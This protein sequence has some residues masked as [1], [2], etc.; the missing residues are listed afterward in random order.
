MA[1]RVDPRNRVVDEDPLVAEKAGRSFRRFGLGRARQ[2]DE[3]ADIPEGL[4]PSATVRRD[5]HYRRALVAADVLAVAASGI[6]A[7]TVLGHDVLRP[8]ACLLLPVV[9][10][11]SKVVGLYDRDPQLLC[12]STL[13][14]APALFQAATF[15]ALVFWVLDGL[16]VDGVLGNGQVLGLWLLLFTFMLVGRGAARSAVTRLTRP[17]RCLVIGSAASALRVRDNLEVNV[18]VNGEVVGRVPLRPERRLGKVPVASGLDALGLTLVEQEIDRVLV[19]PGTADTE[20]ILGIIRLVRSM[21]VK[22]SLVPRLFEAVGSSVDWDAVN[23]VVLLGVRP[24][25]LT[26]S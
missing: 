17:E 18:H 1:Q 25:G 6:V 12:K 19:A 16:V 10:A 20:E 2:R 9:V 8:T 7:V 3:I 14:E 23:G 13:D 21:G 26:R 24:H 4:V 22:V 5:T 11:V 15:F